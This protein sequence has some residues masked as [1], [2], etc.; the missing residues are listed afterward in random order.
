MDYATAVVF[1]AMGLGLALL[2]RGGFKLFRGEEVTERLP[3]ERGVV[4]LDL[5][6]GNGRPTRRSAEKDYGEAAAEG[7]EEDTAENQ[8]AD[9]R[10]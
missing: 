9:G 10:K 5:L 4:R 6:E 1:F 7:S 2:I 8:P 3:I